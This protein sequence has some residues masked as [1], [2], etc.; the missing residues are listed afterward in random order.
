[1]V[2]RV[3]KGCNMEKLKN[4]Y[5]KI[6]SV[7]NLYRAAYVAAKGRRFSNSAADFNFCL[8]DEIQKLRKELAIKTYK[9][10]KYRVFTIRD[11]KVRQISAAP[12]RDRVVHHALHDVIEPL[13]DKSF[14][15]DSYAC[16][17]NKGT[18]KAVDRAQEFLRVNKFCL[19]GDIQKYFPS[20]DHDVLKGLVRQ[21]VE[22]RD[23]LWLFDCIIDS[24]KELA[25]V[26]VSELASGRV[27][28]LAGLTRKYANS[29]T[30]EPIKGLP[31][32]N[33]TS[34]FFAN[35]YLNELDYFVK[36]D[37]KCCHYLRYMDDFLVFGNSKDTLCEIKNRI[38]EFLR[39]SL[40]LS[41]HEGKSQVYKTD[42]GIKFL[43][44]RLF[45]N[46][47]RLTSDNVR[48]F[49]K[50]LKKFSSEW[51]D[52]LTGTRVESANAVT[53]ELANSIR[54][55]VRCWV[56]HAKYA[57]TKRLRYNMWMNL[58]EKEHNLGRLFKGVLVEEK[59]SGL[60]GGRVRELAGEDRR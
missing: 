51:V 46:Y 5:Q 22:D 12:F 1:M 59:V 2:R 4:I 50:R 11:P 39:N 3:K 43:G 19:H 44:F 34:Q 33:L 20:I 36:F 40:S 17:K 26:R 14:V 28:G 48:R 57:D 27:R 45:K 60:A 21:R 58:S 13:F 9:H 42:R 31:I 53:G 32:G 37:L 15:Y 25:G 35:L 30:G 49:R 38:R 6:V 54:D 47:R 24:A 52:K 7:E 8:E 55:S 41:L 23:L 18:H 56:A 16:R 10:G 29:L